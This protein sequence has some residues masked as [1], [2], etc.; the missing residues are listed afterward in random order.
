MVTF[1]QKGMVT[2]DLFYR[3][4]LP[5]QNWHAAIHTRYIAS[6]YTHVLYLYI[7]IYAYYINIPLMG[8][9]SSARSTTGVGGSRRLGQA[10]VRY[11]CFVSA[12][13]M[14]MYCMS[15]SLTLC[16]LCTCLCSQPWLLVSWLGFGPSLFLK[17]SQSKRS[18]RKLETTPRAKALSS[19]DSHRNPL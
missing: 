2:F 18:T 9:G 6:T 13:H 16:I 15:S 11:M 7:Y 10:H 8:L 14:Y 17:L 3:N 12:C 4:L 5:N 19:W 1:V